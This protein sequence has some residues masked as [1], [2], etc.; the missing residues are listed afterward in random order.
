VPRTGLH[1]RVPRARELGW[2]LP[3]H[4]AVLD[5][6]LVHLGADGKPNFAAISRRLVGRRSGAARSGPAATFVACDLLH[7]DGR[8]VRTLPHARRCELLHELLA[9]GPRWRVPRPLDG[10]LEAC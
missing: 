3:A 8:A 10:A 2:A 7:L 1:R 5:G 4:R 6:E 9:D